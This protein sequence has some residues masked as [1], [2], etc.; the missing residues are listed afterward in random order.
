[1]RITLFGGSGFIGRHLAAELARRGHALV[2][3]VRNRERAKNDLI[4]LPQTDVIAYDPNVVST[5]TSAIT[6]ADAVVNLVGILNEDDQCGFDLV[7]GEFVRMLTSGSAAR[8]VSRFI[9]MS[10]IGASASAPSAYLH[11]KAKAE[12][13][14]RNSDSFSYTIIRS[15]VVF[16]DGDHLIN[17]FSTLLRCFPFLPLPC[18]EAK[19][20]PIYVGD[21][22]ALIARV[23]EE[24]IF[25]NRIL[26]AGGSDVMTLH[27]MIKCLATV[28]GVRRK[29]LPFG[30]S[31]SYLTA[32]VMDFTPFV[33]LLT[34]DNY[35]SMRVPSVCPKDEND[36]LQALGRL[37]TLAGGL[38]QMHLAGKSPIDN[39]RLAARR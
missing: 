31:L 24:E 33:N 20:Q 16:G 28:L 27:E 10:A 7:H 13:I 26:H 2:L 37:T 4:L 38:A 23:L 6:G 18:A 15:S 8:G 12:Q 21:L 5:V 3:P 22:V 14:V 30:E 11:S 25:N 9:Q 36:A 39:F 17:Q 34:R 19:I 32:A 35:L 1:M 29:I